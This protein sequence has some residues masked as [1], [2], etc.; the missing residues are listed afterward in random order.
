[1]NRPQYSTLCYNNNAYAQSLVI[2]VQALLLARS[3]FCQYAINENRNGHEDTYINYTHKETDN[4]YIGYG[5]MK[6]LNPLSLS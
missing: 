4:N 1:M 5:D 2:H 6:S 3:S